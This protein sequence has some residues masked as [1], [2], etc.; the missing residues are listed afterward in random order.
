VWNLSV[1]IR[2]LGSVRV[3]EVEVYVV[4]LDRR[5]ENP[6]VFSPSL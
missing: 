5:Q 4:L 1:H 6:E 2:P 3:T